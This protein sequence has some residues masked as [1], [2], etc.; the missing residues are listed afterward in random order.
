[1][2][3]TTFTSAAGRHRYRFCAFNGEVCVCDEAQVRPCIARLIYSY[4]DEIRMTI[5]VGEEDA[6]CMCMRRRDLRLID[7]TFST[8]EALRQFVRT[9]RE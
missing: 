1:V 9:E 5:M 3:V 6:I 8:L 2:K 4:L 7:R